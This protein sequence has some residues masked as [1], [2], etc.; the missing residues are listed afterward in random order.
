MAEGR[1][2]SPIVWKITH[3]MKLLLVSMPHYTYFDYLLDYIV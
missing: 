2:P 1:V 3:K